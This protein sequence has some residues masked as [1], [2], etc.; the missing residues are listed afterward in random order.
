MD[1]IVM[2]FCLSVKNRFVPPLNQRSSGKVSSNPW[3][4]WWLSHTRGK[5]IGRQLLYNKE[6]SVVFLES[7]QMFLHSVNQ[8]QFWNPNLWT[9]IFWSQGDCT[10]YLLRGS[11]S[12]NHWRLIKLQRFVN[13]CKI[14]Y[15]H[16]LN[17]SAPVSTTYQQPI[18]LQYVTCRT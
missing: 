7:H 12:P 16:C 2:V 17:Q 11:L 8:V 14:M 13:N 4:G 9:T 10:G 3:T 18:S 5:K 15:R 6:K 1:V